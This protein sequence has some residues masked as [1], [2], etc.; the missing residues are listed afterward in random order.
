MVLPDC[1]QDAIL[2]YIYK[3]PQATD[4]KSEHIIVTTIVPLSSTNIY[5]IMKDVLIDMIITLDFSL[6]DG[7]DK[8]CMQDRREGV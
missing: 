4:S 3:I 6:D 7:L 1:L 5:M 2:W 8:L